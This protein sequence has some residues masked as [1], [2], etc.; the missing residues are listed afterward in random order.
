MAHKSKK[1]HIKHVRQHE[2][3]SAALKATAKAR[4]GTVQSATRGKAPAGGK[5]PKK[6]G[7]VR[8]IAKATTKK[9][10]ATPRKIIQRATRRVRS[11]VKSMLGRE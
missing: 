3:E 7:I 6:R 10:A 5:A 11:R 9:L 2:A 8:S 1:K 4:A